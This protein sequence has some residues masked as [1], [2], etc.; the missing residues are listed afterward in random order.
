[1]I[2]QNIQDA[3]NQQINKEFYSA[4]LYLSMAAYFNSINLTG[5]ENWMKVQVQEEMMHAMK[6]YTFICQRTGK[7]N[8]DALAKPPVTWASPLEIFEQAYKHEQFV[9]ESIN[10]LVTLARKEQDYASEAFLH[11]FVTEQVE[12]EANTSNL[13]EK[14]KLIKNSS[15]ALL[16]L[17]RELAARVFQPPATPA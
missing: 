10:N 12:E 3:F 2:K 7:V 8:L 14:L 11:W 6:F 15:D 5:F 1:M 16:M 4:Y 17:D 9:T 13:A